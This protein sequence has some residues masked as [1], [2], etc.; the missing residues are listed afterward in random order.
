[1]KKSLT[2]I[3]MTLT[4]LL[5]LHGCTVG[6]DYERPKVQIPERWIEKSCQEYQ[7]EPWVEWWSTFHDPMLNYLIT[8]AIKCNLDLKIALAK[9]RYARGL[10][11]ATKAPMFPRID[12]SAGA[13]QFALSQSFPYLTIDQS[14]ALYDAH[15]D[16]IWELDIF[17]GRKRSIE[18]SL[19]NYGSH[20][21]KSRLVLISLISETAR[22]YIE[23][24]GIQEQL[25]IMNQMVELQKEKLFMKQ[26]E[27]NEALASNV[28]VARAKASLAD[29]EAN[30][31]GLRTNLLQ[32]E[33]RIALILGKL[34]GSLNCALS[35]QHPMPSLPC[36]IPIGLPSTLL[37]RRPDVRQAERELME[38]TANVGVAVA[39]YFPKL[40]LTGSDGQ[41]SQ[42]LKTFANAVN[43]NSVYGFNISWPLFSGGHVAGYVK[44]S[45]GKHQ[46]AFYNY[47]KAILTAFQD[48]ENALIAYN[49]GKTE[50]MLL[51][52]EVEN[53]HSIY[54]NMKLIFQEGLVSYLNVIQAK[55][56]LLTTENDL[57]QS[58][59]QL[60]NHLIL[61][62]KA[63]GGGWQCTLPVLNHP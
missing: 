13:Q 52:I 33:N 28:D 17:G 23:F 14:Y 46:E 43:N 34:P 32:T 11:V 61:L 20:V 21:E 60:T 57:L 37:L 10:Y 59:I 29:M 63:L 16:A 48:V 5:F 35:V 15:F 19:A 6:P 1:M 9:V 12:L 22:N 25:C 49:D 40:G 2:F 53:K 30:I 45:E 54:K 3:I 39:E 50:Y 55:E 8:Q 31:P 27:E 51:Q 56:D 4:L 58:R 47:I 41:L 44:S 26:S 24:R 62:Y 38:A 7:K 18:S 42:Q 36:N